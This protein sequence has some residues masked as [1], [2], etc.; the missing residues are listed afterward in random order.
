MRISLHL[1]NQLNYKSIWPNSAKWRKAF[2]CGGRERRPNSANE[3]VINQG[4][5]INY[6]DSVINSFKTIFL[7]AALIAT[8]LQRIW[9]EL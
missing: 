5:I 6:T 4:Q 7:H 8:S 1:N 2:Q 9:A 3:H